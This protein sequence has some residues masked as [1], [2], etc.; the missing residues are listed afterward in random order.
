MV[1]ELSQLIAHGIIDL[2]VSVLLFILGVMVK[3]LRDTLRESQ[4][5]Y[6]RMTESLHQL[7]MTVTKEYVPRT[8]SDVRNKEI[9]EK[10]EQL[11]DKIDTIAIDLAKV[12]VPHVRR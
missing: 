6:Q 11:S 9:W 7:A 12:G 10:L 5:D 8:D 2:I 4:K 1:N 3:S